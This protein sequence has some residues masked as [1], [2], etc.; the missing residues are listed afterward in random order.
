MNDWFYSLK[1]RTMPRFLRLQN[2]VIHVPSV[3]NVTMGTTCFGK[4][5]LSIS[6]YT[7][8]KV[9]CLSYSNW[10]LCEQQF[11]TLK[12]AM[13]EIEGLLAPVPLTVVEPQVEAPKKES[14]V[15]QP[16]EASA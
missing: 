1:A 6:Y 15:E 10:T 5:Y 7:S 8:D 9:V 2:T 14:V 4:P 13:K 12:D 16:T 3:S 11:N